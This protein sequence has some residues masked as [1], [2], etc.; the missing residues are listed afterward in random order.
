[1]IFGGRC[2]RFTLKSAISIYEEPLKQA[3]DKGLEFGKAYSA[4]ILL[5]GPVRGCEVFEF[6]R[7]GTPEHDEGEEGVAKRDAKDLVK[8]AY[9]QALE[10]IV[11]EVE[12]EQDQTGIVLLA[13]PHVKKNTKVRDLTP[14]S[15]QREPNAD[16]FKYQGVTEVT[17]QIIGYRRKGEQR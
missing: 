11:T 4:R 17:L 1:M 14:Y 9:Q 12:A 16:E 3:T 2:W 13:D 8:Q 10:R 7:Y 15:R 6:L 5:E